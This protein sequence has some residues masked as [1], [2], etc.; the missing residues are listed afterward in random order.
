M[1][2]NRNLEINASLAA[3]ATKRASKSCPFKPFF[4]IPYPVRADAQNRIKIE[5]RRPSP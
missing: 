3:V 5:S 1:A 4:G 2:L